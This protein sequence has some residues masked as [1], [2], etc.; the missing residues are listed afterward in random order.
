MPSA[1]KPRLGKLATPV[2]A[3]FPSEISS[4][5]TA[6]PV[7]ALSFPFKPD[8]DYIRTPISPPVA[9]T[10]FLFKASALGSPSIHCGETPSE[11][12]PTTASTSSAAST[13]SSQCSGAR[14]RCERTI[15]TS[16]VSTS[17]SV[18]E[19]L[20][21]ATAPLVPPSPFTTSAPMSAPPTGPAT[22]PSL[23]LPLSPAISSANSP[24]AAK[25]PFSARSVHSVFDWDAALRARF[26]EQ[27]KQ[28][29]A[30]SNVRH[31]REVVTRT[32]TYTPRMEPAPRGK[33]RKVE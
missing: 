24:S 25:S 27:K 12:A 1:D 16:S 8:P 10:D 4:A 32:V 3:A 31:I 13:V 22:F 2:T 26:A 19:K 9:Y 5:N 21:P 30:R 14:G 6:T 15:S 11:S 7:S 18:E 28:K 17:G 33:R 29:A 20:P 23:K